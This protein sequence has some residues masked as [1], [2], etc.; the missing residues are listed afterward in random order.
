MKKVKKENNIKIENF[1][2]KFIIDNFH[3]CGKCDKYLVDCL[4]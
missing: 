1:E 4:C 2:K 3:K